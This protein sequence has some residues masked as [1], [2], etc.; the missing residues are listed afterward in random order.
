MLSADSVRRVVQGNL[1]NKGASILRRLQTCA[2]VS[3]SSPEKNYPDNFES[4]ETESVPLRNIALADSDP[5]SVLFALLA[6]AFFH[7]LGV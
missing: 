5:H 1:L 2:L 7:R 4:S 6:G 3:P